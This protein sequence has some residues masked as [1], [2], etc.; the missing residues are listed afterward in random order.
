M[1]PEN[2]EEKIEDVTVKVWISKL[3]SDWPLFLELRAAGDI[4]AE[5]AISFGKDLGEGLEDCVPYALD[6]QTVPEE[7]YAYHSAVDLPEPAPPAP[8]APEVEGDLT[9]RVASLESCLGS[10]KASLDEIV[11]RLPAPSQGVTLP[12]KA[13]PRPSALRPPR[14]AAETDQEVPLAGLDPAVVQAARTAGVPEAHLKEGELG[15]QEQ[16]AS[17]GAKSR[18]ATGCQ[19]SALRA[20]A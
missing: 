19:T 14:R 16:A 18:C 1:G 12:L 15:G 4:E 3:A 2:R 10:V 6:L 7:R 11:S 13:Q 9:A 8:R 20:E 17:F 5:V